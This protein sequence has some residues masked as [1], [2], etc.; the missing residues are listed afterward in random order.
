L[1]QP[2]LYG[3]AFSPYVRLCRLVAAKSGVEIGFELADPFDPAFRHLNPLGK[4]P[5]LLVEEGQTLLDTGLIC[6]TLMNRGRDLLPSDP[7][8]RLADEAM[9][10]VLTGVLDLGVAWVMESRRE[11]DV[12][13]HWQARRLEGIAAAFPLIDRAAERARGRPHSYLALALITT[14]QWLDFRLGDNALWRDQCPD[15]RTF[16]GS[17]SADPNISSTAP[18]NA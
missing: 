14:L 8:E 18:Q 16:L 9:I 3:S 4:V 12:S 1:S 5:A 6:R 7:D 15:A 2:V 17:L 11:R 10:A 13:E